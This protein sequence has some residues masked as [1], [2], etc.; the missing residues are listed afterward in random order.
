VFV[1]LLLA[2]ILPRPNA[3]YQ[4]AQLPQLGTGENQ[5]SNQQSLGKER[6][7]HQKAESRKASGP[8][9]DTQKNK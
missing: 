2:A 7:D 3:E 9:I 1:V 5:Q 8:K 6:A 4:L